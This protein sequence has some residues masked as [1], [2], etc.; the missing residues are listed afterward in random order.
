MKDRIATAIHALLRSEISEDEEELESFADEVESFASVLDSV[1]TIE[2]GT[3]LTMGDGSKFV[4][5][6][7]QV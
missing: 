4:V 1:D 2:E 6:I 5:I 7:K 3:L